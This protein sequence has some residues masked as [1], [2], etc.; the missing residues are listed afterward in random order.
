MNVERLFGIIYYLLNNKKSST[1]KLA[2]KFEV[3]IRTINRD[4]NKLSSVGIPI[5][6]EVGRNG[7]VYLLD[8]FVLDNVLLSNEEQNNLLLA[9]NSTKTINPMTSGESIA[10]LQSLFQKKGDDW[11][12]IDLSNW[13][14]KENTNDKFELIK[15]SILNKNQIEFRYISPKNPNQIRRCHPYKLVYKS[16]AWYLHALCLAKNEFRYFKL[17]RMSDVHGTKQSFLPKPLPEMPLLEHKNLSIPLQLEFSKEIFY[18]VYDEFN[19]ND[20]Q[21]TNTET[22]L[23]KTSFPDGEWL[24]RY[25]LSFGK[26]LK[27]LSP[28]I[29]KIRVNE[30]LTKM[31]SNITKF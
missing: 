19:H 27:I 30:E 5:Y 18:R 1:T 8:N 4:I 9:L 13:Y 22:L 15:T 12:E 29:I 31:L 28:D 24:I 16:Q 23:V 26:H 14:Q 3:S 20:I 10:K 17:N 25:L 11:L 2:E 7:G 21:L 6:T